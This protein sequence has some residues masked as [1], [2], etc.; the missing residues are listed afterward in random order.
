M[1]V[2]LSSQ[3][4]EIIDHGTVLLFSENADFTLK[5]VSEEGLEVE[6]TVLFQENPGGKQEVQTDVADNHVTLTCINFSATGT[7]M[8]F[9]VQIA[10]LD[11]KTIYFIF[12]AYLDGTKGN[13]AKV[14]RIVYTLYAE[15]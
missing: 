12:W 14:R 2:K 1:Q 9:P 8:S 15:E 10:V 5:M 3:N 11:G 7:G 13:Q 4:R 6:L